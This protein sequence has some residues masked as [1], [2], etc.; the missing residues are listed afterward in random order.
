MKLQQE[1]VELF[2]KLNWGLLYYANKKF[3]IIRNLSAPN[4]KGKNIEE[5]TK[6]EDKLFNGTKIIEDFIRENPLNFNYDELNIIREWKNFIRE[7]FFIFIEKD[8]AIFLTSEKEPKAYNV[9]GISEDIS[10][11]LPFEPYM[12]KATL[13]PF[14]G[15]IIYSGIFQGYSISFGS[16]MRKAVYKDFIKAKSS[17]GIIESLGLP[18]QRKKENNEE[19]LKFYLKNEENR[20]E[21]ENE[22]SNILKKEPLLTKTYYQE[23]S[24]SNSRKLRKKISDLNIKSGYFAVLNDVIIASGKSEAEVKES[25]KELLGE[26]WEYA[27]IFK[28]GGRM[29]I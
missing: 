12:V 2:Y 4:L 10:E 8:N 20:F 24:K 3:D 7:E 5:I 29:K 19:L 28:H 9:Y 13:L 27:Y 18:L 14:R 16:G 25:L 21:Y 17:F 22:I 26:R 6:L 1:E 23:L 15:K 11:I